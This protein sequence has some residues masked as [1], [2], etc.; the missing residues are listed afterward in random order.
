M[1]RQQRRRWSDRVGPEATEAAGFSIIK[2]PGF[3]SHCSGMLAT[4]LAAFLL[5]QPDVVQSGYIRTVNR[6]DGVSISQTLSRRFTATGKPDLWLVGVA[7]IGLKEYYAQIQTL[8]DAQGMVLFEGVRANDQATGMPV[9]DSRAPKNLYQI[10]SGFIGLDFQPEDIH[11]NHPNWV[12][13][14]V[15]LD[16]IQR[17][18]K[19]SGKDKPAAL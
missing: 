6:T 14:D 16:E 17:L 19:A 3:P 4:L 11:Y 7:H 1:N 5:A 13:S 10:L 9:A 18:K 15:S 2:F 8:L 12:N